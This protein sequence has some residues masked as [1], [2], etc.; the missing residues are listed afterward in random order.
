M[1]NKLGQKSFKC[2]LNRANNRSECVISSR[3]VSELCRVVVTG[4]GLVC[5][6]GVGADQVWN[7][8]IQGKSGVS[9]VVGDGYESIPCKIAAYVPQ[10]DLKLEQKFSKNEL[11]TLTK[12]T[13]F[14]LIASEEALND[15]KWKPIK[16]RDRTDTGVAVG[17]GMI[18]MDEVIQNGNALR[19]DGFNRVS[20]HFVTKLLVNMPAGHISIR[21]GLNGPNHSVSTACTTGVHAIG[22]A[23]NFIQRGAANVMVCGGTESVINPLSMAAFARIR[24]LCTQFNDR[25]TEASRPFDAKRCGFVMGE[26]A[27]IVVLEELTHALARDAKIYAEVLGYGLSGIT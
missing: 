18:D 6:L 9:K 17:M 5:P 3:N 2:L 25:P 20:P 12:A 1:L 11:R 26:G 7:N 10:K 16:E 14:A 24:A 4:I 15:A 27:G 19:N 23:F 13:L 21:Y 22:D 8:L